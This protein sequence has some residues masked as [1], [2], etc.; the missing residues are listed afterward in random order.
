ME[1]GPHDAVTSDLEPGNIEVRAP[2]VVL[3]VRLDEATG[4]QLHALAKRRGIR[5]SDVLREAAES[6]ARMGGTGGEGFYRLVGANI[7]VAVGQ[8]QILT[9]GM[10]RA[11]TEPQPFEPVLERA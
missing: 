8:Q 6:Y 2:S 4:R 10:N 9:T 3:S 7:D 5:I 11:R 1:N